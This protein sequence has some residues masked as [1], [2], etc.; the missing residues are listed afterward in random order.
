[1]R[2]LLKISPVALLLSTAAYADTTV[3]SNSTANITTST[4]GN[5]TVSSGVTVQPASGAVVTIDSNNT[6]NNA[7]TLF[8]NNVDNSA[9]VVANAGVTSTITNSG[10]ITVNDS[11]AA[12]DS[13]GDGI[14][15]GAFAQGT[16]RYGIHLLGAY[17]G[18]VINSGTITVEG[19]NSAGVAADGAITGNF[20]HTGGTISVLGDNGYGVKL[21]AVSGTV[22]LAGTVTAQG[23][24]STAV[25]LTGDIGGSVVVHGTLTSTGYST[26]T[27]PS[28]QSTLLASNLL[29]GGSA[30]VIGG[31]VAGGVLLAAA[32]TDT[33]NTTADV[34]GD[35]IADASE[36][37]TSSLV[38]SGSAPALL[39]GSATQAITLGV[40]PS[41]TSG[42]VLNGTITGQGLYTGVSGTAVQIGG[43]GQ[44]VTITGGITN[45]GTITATSNGGQA[46][47]IYAASGAVI[48]TITNTGTII[49]SAS[50]ATGGSSATIL[51]GAGASVPTIVNNGTLTAIAATAGG[52]ATAVLDQS[53][54]LTSLSNSSGITAS[55][56]DGTA[57]AIDVSANTTGFTYTQAAGTSTAP[58]T[59][60]AIVTGSGNDTIAVSAGTV[61]GNA[62]LGAGNNI[63]ALS[64]TA[65]YTGNIT[66]GAGNDVLT[67]AD[68]STYAGTVDFGAGTNSLS[69]GSG[70][71]FTGTI[72]A[73]SQNLAASVAS[74]GTLSLTSTGTTALSSLLL[75]GTL[76][77]VVNP[78]SGTATQLAVSGAT[79]IASGATLKAS[80]SSLSINPSTVSIISSG[81]LTG[82]SNLTLVTTS[83]PYLLTASLS[84]NDATGTVSLTV[85]PKTT[86]QLGLGRAESSAYPAVLTAIAGNSTLSTLF[87]GL[88]DQAS[89]VRRYRQMLPDYQGGVFDLLSQ[90]ARLMAPSSNGVSLGE[91]G[92]VQLW[93]QQAWWT[94][95]Q[96]ATSDG[97]P[98]YKGTG[99]G[100]TAGGDIGL[101]GF[102]RVGLSLGYIYADAK[103]GVRTDVSANDFQGGVHWLG[104]WGGLSLTANGTAGFVRFNG[105]RN[106]DNASGSG[107][108][109]TSNGKWNGLLI[110]GNFAAS[111]QANLGAFYLRPTGTLTYAHLKENGHS[112]SGGGSGY[113]LTVA[114]RTSS[115]TAVNATL[116]AGIRFGPKDDPEATVFRF[117]VEGGRREILSG[118][119]G[120]TTANFAGGQ[121]FTLSPDDR[122]SGYLGTGRVILGSSL[123]AFTIS[124]TY[125]TRTNDY[126]VIV[127][128][129][130]IRASI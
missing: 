68:T 66:Y 58:Y 8:V 29:Q 119:I 17:S 63:V 16:G 101:G 94:A 7:G 41:G 54:T 9:G 37:T 51:I 65:A 114:K 1:M 12:T 130:G 106:L 39:V 73:T 113:D 3:G 38:T 45:A 87:L 49:G 18:D 34:D 33:T 60:G 129:L 116:A 22:A 24:N 78:T 40:V 62:S 127:G 71:T 97:A 28:D 98:G 36:A 53:G 79:T 6:V 83:L 2:P 5:V 21:G 25:A 57:R 67:L 14:V 72:A 84:G 100:L 108:L 20:R 89:T 128:R 122:Q 125:E 124:G 26:T 50:T 123:F 19:N 85:A 99:W 118:S 120:S 111:Y 74:G 30:L 59:V 82:S 27:V 61:K 46:L 69:I 76:A 110:S 35:G 32:T 15:D 95:N 86:A 93:A 88:T 43:L 115:E 90:G 81:T 11:Y 105:Q 56:T 80:V 103:S 91:A 55:N 96:G 75:G 107:I 42:L 48:P 70:A 23:Q 121:S 10:T 4:A 47:G 92:N 44:S 13:N 109:L 52:M 104:H 126:H 77:I 117:E 64:G 31:N 102:G 112:D